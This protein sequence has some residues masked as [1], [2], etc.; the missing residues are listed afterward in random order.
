M[1]GIPKEEIDLGLAIIGHNLKKIVAKK[2]TSKTAGLKTQLKTVLKAF[3]N[4][5]LVLQ[6]NFYELQINL[7]VFQS[8]PL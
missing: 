6:G 5:I 4:P 7:L 1:R 3:L 2:T 8:N